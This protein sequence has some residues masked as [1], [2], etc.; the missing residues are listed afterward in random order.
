MLQH[1]FKEVCIKYEPDLKKDIKV[2]L[3]YHRTCPLYW[4]FCRAVFPSHDNN[5]NIS[6]LVHEHEKPFYDHS[7]FVQ[8]NYLNIR[9]KCYKR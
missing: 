5:H 9:P 6:Q 2:K 8:E 1:P 7:L 3:V 4:N